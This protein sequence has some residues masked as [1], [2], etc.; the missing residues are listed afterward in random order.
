MTVLLNPS[1]HKPLLGGVGHFSPGGAN[2]VHWL[3]EG[4]SFLSNEG[5][6]FNFLEI[7]FS[8][9]FFF[10]KLVERDLTQSVSLT[11]NMYIQAQFT[12]SYFPPEIQWGGKNKKASLVKEFSFLP[13]PGSVWCLLWW[14]GWAS[15]YIQTARK[16]SRKLSLFLIIRGEITIWLMDLHKGKQ[17]SSD[18]GSY[19]CLSCPRRMSLRPLSHEISWV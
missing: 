2:V 18:Q 7:K 17:I 13:I 15:K 4:A 12:T 9:F 16:S 19:C 5:S 11:E 14:Q 1:A 8:G 6:H 3:I 10:L